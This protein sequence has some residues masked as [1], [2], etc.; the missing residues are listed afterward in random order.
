MRK[1]LLLTL[2]LLLSVGWMLA[3]QTPRGTANSS[4]NEST[5]QGCLSNSAGSFTLTDK[6]GKTYWLEGDTAKLS[7]HVG[8]EVRV[9]GTE[10]TAA[11][12][13]QGATG[14]AGTTTEAKRRINVTKMEHVSTSCSTA[15]K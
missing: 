8:H 12:G 14:T 11:S 7:D 10:S 13:S 6:A 5:I 9:T 2:F 3:Q 1:T 15:Q 4:A